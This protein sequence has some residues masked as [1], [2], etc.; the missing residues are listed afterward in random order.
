[1]TSA[2]ATAPSSERTLLPRR[3]QSIRSRAALLA[4]AAILG[5][6]LIAYIV[7]P[8]V[9]KRVLGKH[10]QLED[11]PRIT[12]TGSKI[13]GDPLNVS[14]IGT[15]TELITIM[16][17]AN[18][19]RA[20]KLGWRSDLRIASATVLRRPYDE[21]PVSNL[22]VWGRKEDLAFE[23]PVGND[24]VKRHH[25]R[26]WRSPDVDESGRPIWVGSDTFDQS[27]GLSHTTGQIT[28]HIAADLDTERNQLFR[29]LQETG[30]LAETYSVE[31]FQPKREG[32]NGGGDRW[33]TDGN[34]EVGV[35][36]PSDPSSRE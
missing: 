23:K 6:L 15:E 34:M 35:I 25:V 18:W 17:K 7:V 20:A 24:P 19:F 32:K 14:L 13:P 22:Y 27:V 28:H 11:Y 29:D 30:E 2:I 36:K 21:A 4:A 9:W 10:P 3:R 1:M 16:E 31:G 5:Y 33:H 12:H 8:S 26:F